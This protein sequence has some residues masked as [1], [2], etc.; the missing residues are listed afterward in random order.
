MIVGAQDSLRFVRGPD[1][2]E[3]ILQGRY[4][5]STPADCENHMG[6]DSSE[7]KSIVQEVNVNTIKQTE[8]DMI[9]YDQLEEMAMLNIYKQNGRPEEIN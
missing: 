3:V 7:G 8:G 9:D 5:S 2:A 6:N 4:Q 1:V